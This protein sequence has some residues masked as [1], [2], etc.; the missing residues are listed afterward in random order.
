MGPERAGCRLE[1]NGHLSMPDSTVNTCD[2]AA[3]LA[4]HF[5]RR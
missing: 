3:W 1:F 5:D 2:L 4:D